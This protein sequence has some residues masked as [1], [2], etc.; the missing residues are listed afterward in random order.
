[1]CQFKK[2]NET[3]MISIMGR[4]AHKPFRLKGFMLP[5]L[6]LFFVLTPP[7]TVGSGGEPFRSVPCLIDLRTTWSDGAHNLEEIIETARSRGFRVLVINDHDRLGVSYGIPPF[8]NLLR[9]RKSFPSIMTRGPGEYLADIQRVSAKYPDMIIIAGCE[10]SAFY[11]WTGSWLKKNLT[12]NGYDRKLLIVNFNSAEDYGRIPNVGNSLSLRYTKRL[13]PGIIVFLVPF[14]IGIILLR[15]KGIF[16]TMG[17]LIAVFSL[18]AMIDYNPFRSSPFNIYEGDPGIAPCQE[19]IDYVNERG[20]LCFW[21]YPE[22]RSGIRKEGQVFLNTPPYPE[23]LL[24]SRD[25]TGFSA[26]YGD[27]ITVTE[28]GKE[29][30]TV[31]NEYCSGRRARPAWGISTADFHKDG[32][33][34]IPLGAFPTTLYL[35]DFSRAGVIEAMRAGRMYCSRGDGHSWPRLEDF[36]LAGEEGRRAC[37]GETLATAV[38]PVV[39]FRVTSDGRPG[40]MTLLLIRGGALIGTFEGTPPMEVEYLDRD[41]PPGARTYYRVMDRGKALTSNPIFVEYRK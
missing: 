11:Y 27:E 34:G 4:K 14:L 22:Q 30:D 19:L 37:M 26:I 32:A 28:P 10:T 29:W 15:W 38:P 6:F 25:Y 31:L 13:L 2:T 1:M 5:A 16:R 23:V 18:F 39:R 21:N 17:L 12:L 33:L 20:G 8:R 41:A 24:Q 9:Y 35:K 3:D 36:H 7:T 40:P